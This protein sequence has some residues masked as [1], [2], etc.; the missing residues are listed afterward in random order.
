MHFGFRTGEKGGADLRPAGAERER[1][2]DATAIG[3]G[4]G[5]DHRQAHRIDHLR[6]QGEGADAAGLDIA[7]ESSAVPA[8]LMALRDDGI[9]ATRL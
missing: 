5:G 8:G 2:R 7:K 6:H 9:G 1:R 3:D 4:A